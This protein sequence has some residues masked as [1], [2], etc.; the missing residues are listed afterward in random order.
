MQA[1]NG[2][3]HS[4]TPSAKPQPLPNRQA[5]TPA[6]CSHKVAISQR[7]VVFGCLRR[8]L[9]T[10]TPSAAARPKQGQNKSACQAPWNCALAICDRKVAGMM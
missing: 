4:K 2:A 3:P 6:A 8:R 7:R 10:P 1:R 9:A 5:N